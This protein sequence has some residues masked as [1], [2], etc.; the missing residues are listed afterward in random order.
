[1]GTAATPAAS[2]APADGEGASQEDERVH[3]FGVPM[4]AF[5]PNARKIR[6]CLLEF[7]C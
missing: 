5:V 2:G 3:L 1:V 7:R 4:P 6:G